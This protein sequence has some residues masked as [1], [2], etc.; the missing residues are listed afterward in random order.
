M[1]GQMGHMKENG[2][3]SEET[4]QFIAM[5]F[6]APIFLRDFDDRYVILIDVPAFQCGLA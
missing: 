4:R 6:G 5:V 2:T 3:Q 1:Y